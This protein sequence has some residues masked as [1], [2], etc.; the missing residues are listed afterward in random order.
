MNAPSVEMIAAHDFA[1]IRAQVREFVRGE[2]VPRE[3]EIAETDAIP[4]DI[5]QKAAAMACSATPYRR[6]SAA[7][8]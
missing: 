3:R 7:W 2:V 5:R 4:A 6:S 1:Q 8:A